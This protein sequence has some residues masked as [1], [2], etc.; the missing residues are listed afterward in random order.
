MFGRKTFH[1][2]YQGA[3]DPIPIIGKVWFIGCFSASSHLIDT[4]EGLILI[5]TGYEDTL[6]YW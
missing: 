3:M 4:G 5:D 6:F 2:H 1:H